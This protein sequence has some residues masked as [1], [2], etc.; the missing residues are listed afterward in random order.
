LRHTG[1]RRFDFDEFNLRVC[2]AKLRE[3]GLEQRVVARVVHETKVI[4][5][6]GIETNRKNVFLKQNRLR[7][8]E[9]APGERTD[10]ANSFNQPGPQ[11][12]QIGGNGWCFCGHD[13][14]SGFL[15]GGVSFCGWTD[16][17]R[18]SGS[19][20]SNARRRDAC[21]TKY[22]FFQEGVGGNLAFSKKAGFPQIILSFD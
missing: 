6:F 17:R 15:M 11:P 21:A 16:C 2:M 13:R 3:F 9:I 8:H 10:A 19:I 1:G 20:S 5:K 4:F 22:I 7:I 12:G 14:R 18:S